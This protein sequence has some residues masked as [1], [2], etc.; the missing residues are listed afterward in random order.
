MNLKE[1]KEIAMQD[2][3]L[4]GCEQHAKECE[5]CNSIQDSQ[6]TSKDCERCQ[7]DLYFCRSKPC[8]FKMHCLSTD[9]VKSK[10][11]F[12]F[13]EKK[14]DDQGFRDNNN[15]NNRRSFDWNNK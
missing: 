14:R 9:C 2:K 6:K 5:K 7:G 11:K 15:F 13:G 3:V 4:V 1:K 8:T 12:V 10:H